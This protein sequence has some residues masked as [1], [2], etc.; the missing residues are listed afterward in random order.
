MWFFDP[1]AIDI[2]CELGRK[3]QKHP[4]FTSP[5]AVNFRIVAPF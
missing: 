1:E 3:P 4:K 2:Y 5:D